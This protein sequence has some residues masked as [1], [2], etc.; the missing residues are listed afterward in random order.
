MQTSDSI[1]NIAV[2]LTVFHKEVSSVKKKETNPFF[3]NKYADL[4]AVLNAIKEPLEKSGLS[5]TQFPDKNG[6]NTLLMH[7]SGEWIKARMEFVL[8]KQNPQG[9][10]SAITYGR[11][12][13]LGAVLGLITENDDD[14]NSA[15][16]S[17]QAPQTA[18]NPASLGKCKDCNSDLLAGR[19]GKP[20]CKPCYIKWAEANKPKETIQEPTMEELNF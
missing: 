9:Q 6:L 13:A 16:S 17:P 5:F 7:S 15:N 10:G 3:K 1:K 2:A 8:D 11:R 19:G 12:Y 20:Y 4:T 14:G 18:P